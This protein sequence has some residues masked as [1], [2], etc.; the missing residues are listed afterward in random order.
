[1]PEPR[2]EAFSASLKVMHDAFLG[3]LGNMYSPMI[4]D[5]M[6]DTVQLLIWTLASSLIY[7]VGALVMYLF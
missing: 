5:T 3:P 6:D 4:H 1:M 7:L 2:I